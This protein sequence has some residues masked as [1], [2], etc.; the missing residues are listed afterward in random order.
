MNVG[1]L[2][3]QGAVTPHKEKL[4]ALGV[5]A[6]EVR[7]PADLQNIQGLI[8]PGGES[9][10]FLHLLKLN[11]LWEPLK[12]FVREKPT[13]GICA[14]A[15]LLA[16][17]VSHPEQ[18]S[19]DALDIDIE[20]NAYGRQISSFVDDLSPSKNWPKENEF[21]EGVFIRAPIIKRVGAEVK[22][23]FMHGKDTVMVQSK[24]VLASTFHPE[25]TDSTG[26]HEYFIKNVVQS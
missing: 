5:T 23:L 19:L 25:L 21:K 15:I 4:R 11:K 13:W 24:N 2:A 9:S 16:K 20:R 18:E 14:G 10:T 12:D 7:M 3:L 17:N 1:I 8:I 6:T 26:V 22:P